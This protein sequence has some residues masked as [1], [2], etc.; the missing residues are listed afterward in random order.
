MEHL[1]CPADGDD[2]PIAVGT[3]A[4]LLL[5]DPK[6]LCPAYRKLPD[7]SFNHRARAR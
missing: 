5:E 3:H 2:Q 1:G 6:E 4:G 7:Q